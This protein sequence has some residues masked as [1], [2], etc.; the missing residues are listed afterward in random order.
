MGGLREHIR[1]I[2]VGTLD[3]PDQ[4]LPDVHIFTCSKQPWVILP[5]ED[6]WVEVVYD[7][8]E[9]WSPASLKRLARIEV[10]AGIA[11]S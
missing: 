9:T 1:F 6:R 2:R 8:K 7:F 5:S 10:S 11:I 3:D 4:L